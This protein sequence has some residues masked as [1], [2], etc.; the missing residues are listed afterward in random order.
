MRPGASW[1]TRRHLGVLAQWQSS[2]LLIRWFRVRPPGA[3]PSM[4]CSFS[5]MLC[6]HV[7]LL[8]H[9]TGE[10]RGQVSSCFYS[11]TPS[12]VRELASRRSSLATFLAA[13]SASA[14]VL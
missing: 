1:P 4:T 6:R 14:A 8:G 5:S 3:P 10:A 12:Q 9:L 11:G 2:G 7:A 13:H